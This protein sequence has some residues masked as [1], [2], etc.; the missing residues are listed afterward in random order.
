MATQTLLQFGP[1]VQPN[2]VPRQIFGEV[3][4]TQNNNTTQAGALFGGLWH[5]TINRAASALARMERFFGIAPA[6]HSYLDPTGPVMPAAL[7]IED[8]VS[9]LITAGACEVIF[10]IFEHVTA[11][12]LNTL[13][14]IGFRAGV[15]NIW[16]TFVNDCPGNAPPVTVRHD[17]ATAALMTAQHKLTIIIDG[18]T[19]TITWKIDGVTVDSWTPPTP[20]DQ[21][22][23][24][25]GPKLGYAAIAPLNANVTIRMHGG[26]LPLLRLVT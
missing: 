22:S 3:A 17:V 21:M 6:F 1:D 2:A 14:G 4:A 26:G 8:S 16:H 15:D 20:L 23:P 5:Y 10:G 18:R 9:G 7:V 24:T 25:P 12:T 11:N 13:V 19:K